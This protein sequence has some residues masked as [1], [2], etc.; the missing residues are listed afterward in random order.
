METRAHVAPEKTTRSINKFTRPL[1][2]FIPLYTHVQRLTW[3]IDQEEQS[4]N[5]HQRLNIPTKH[6]VEFSRHA[7]THS[8]YSFGTNKGIESSH[9]ESVSISLLLPSFSM[10][11]I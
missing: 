10:I 4:S 9:I 3:M 1:Y 7:G 5:A 2:P 6:D 8:K 11:M